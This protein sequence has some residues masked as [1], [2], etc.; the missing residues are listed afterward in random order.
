MKKTAIVLILL[1]SG[2]AIFAAL[3]GIPFEVLHQ[4]TG[5]RALSMGEACVA[6]P[7]GASIL[8]W[9]PAALDS[10]EKNT[11]YAA[12]ESLFEGAD[13]EY[14]SYSMPVGRYGGIGFLIGHLGYGTYEPVDGSGAAS[15]AEDMKDMF[16]SAGYGKNLFAGIQAGISAK[17]LI[18]SAFDT[19][20]PVFNA[21]IALRRSFELIDIGLAFK[22][23]LPM[24]VKFTSESEKTVA[25]MRLGFDL[26]FLDNKLKV[27]ADMEKYFIK[28]N[29]LLFA[30]AEYNLLDNF[31]IRAGYNTLSEISAGL[32]FA[33]EGASIDY[34]FVYNSLGLSHK[35]G[36]SYSFGGYEAALKADPPN[37]SPVGAYK[38]TYI[39]ISALTKYEIFKWTIEIKD[40]KGE[41]L[42]N[43]YG[44]GN[45]D[46]EVVW[47]GLRTD[48]MPYEDGD[49]TAVM[50]IVDENDTTIKSEP[51]KIKIGSNELRSLPLFGE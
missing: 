13:K 42:K 15:A 39:R 40:K 32:G 20:T 31:F 43:W 10:V 25:T 17:M 28:E 34:G 22:N 48:G 21:D 18:M 5:I 1:F 38:K 8:F 12:G 46:T 35:A 4:T 14:V 29:P 3:G 23:V 44:A 19:N 47:D 51:I 50:T 9:N 33:M 2:C 45:P 30:G 7:D 11:L 37:F 49:Y 26:K 41:V 16:I 24:E 36:L 27:A 6:D